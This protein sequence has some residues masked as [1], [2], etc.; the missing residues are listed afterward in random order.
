MCV[1]GL[2]IKIADFV[3]HKAKQVKCCLSGACGLDLPWALGGSR[4][5]LRQGSGGHAA[6]GKAVTLV[7]ARQMRKVRR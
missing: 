4:F 7:P 6:W 1:L 5:R 3:P 2:I